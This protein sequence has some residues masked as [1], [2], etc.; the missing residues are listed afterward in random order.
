[1]VWC[2]WGGGEGLSGRVGELRGK[3]MLR[4]NWKEER[5]KG[6]GGV[7]GG[8]MMRGKKRMRGN[9][10]EGREVGGRGVGWEGRVE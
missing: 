10:G 8:G 1:M 6:N 4:G 3:K 5:V 7:G 2:V 9:S